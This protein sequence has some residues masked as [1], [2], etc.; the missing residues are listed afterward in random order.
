MKHNIFPPY[1]IS[2]IGSLPRSSR[3]QRAK[4]EFT[5]GL[6][7]K[8]VYDQ[9]VS[10]ETLKVVNLQVESGVD[11]VS[12]G[13]ITRDNY[14]S[15]ISE[16]VPGFVSMTNEEIL[17]IVSEKQRDNLSESL[18]K[19]NTKTANLYNPICCGKIDTNATF[20]YQTM[21]LLKE[22]TKKPIKAT[23][24]SPYLLT[25]TTW[26][27]GIT[28]NYYSSREDLGKDIVTLLLN[29]VNRLINLKVDVI[30]LDDPIL[31]EIVLNDDDEESFFCG[32]LSEKIRYDHE[33]VFAM[34]L[35]K[36]V[37]DKISKSPSYSCLHV[38]RGN[39]TKNESSLLSGSYT[40]L[41]D[42]FSLIQ[43][44]VMTLEF[45]TDRA[46]SIKELYVNEFLSDHSILGLGVVNPRTENVETSD[47]IIDKVTQAQE[48]LSPGHIWL[49]PDCGFATFQQRPMN[50]EEII[51]N[52]IKSM[53][54]AQTILRE[55]L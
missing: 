22:L 37:L 21:T 50:T 14:I 10:E 30:Q 44:D 35:I 47:F 23:L 54:L 16:F 39:F 1:T 38:C 45:S 8:S 55:R 29:E 11:I 32:R 42:F 40:S 51:K 46:G 19:R 2:L 53:K 7:S 43:P 12:S 18:V 36:P 4:T 20:E 24:P 33:L 34:N 9:I 6:I 48:F 25:R 13:E 15:F 41:S 26:L 17:S 52:K 5:D 27:T 28:D 3:I 31:A 49:N